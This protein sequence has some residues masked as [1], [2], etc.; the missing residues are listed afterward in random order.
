MTA[1][2][3]LLSQSLVT[4]NMIMWVC[5]P[6][7]IALI[8]QVEK[9]FARTVSVGIGMQLVALNLIRG[10]ARQTAIHMMLVPVH[11]TRASS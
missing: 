2:F 6:V 4:T 10:F 11:K 1:V 3:V 9:R 8:Q 7:C 5:M